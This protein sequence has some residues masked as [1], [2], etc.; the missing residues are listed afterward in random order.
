MSGH[1]KTGLN[2]TTDVVSVSAPA[3][4]H[5]G[6]L[7]MHGGLGRR[8]GGIGMAVSAPATRLGLTRA[9]TTLVEGPEKSRARWHLEAMRAHLGISHHHHHLSITE[10]IPAHAG[11]GSGTQLA[12]AVA[13]ALRRLNNLPLDP[14]GDAAFLG[15]G[16]RSGVGAGFFTDG[17][18]L[19]DGGK[20]ARDLPP[21][22]IA[23]LPF[24][25]AWRVILVLD[26]ASHGLAGSA[27]V[28]AF[29]ALP[30]F[31]ERTAADICRLVLMQ[32]L[33]ALAE[34]DLPN[35]GAALS[36][37][38]HRVGEHF[39][40]AQGG[41]FTSPRV[42]SAMAQLKASGA[43]GIGQSSWGPTGFAFAASAEEA[44]AMVA[45]LRGAGENL[46]IRVVEGRNNGASIAGHV[47]AVA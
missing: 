11:L 42:A 12:L 37:I 34:T 16:S 29:A 8:F 2:V 17:G 1:Q 3:R 19:V 23:R 9:A 30:K 6:F 13:A 40:S 25:A 18:F 10:V 31:S 4:L 27:E 28:D 39:S 22:V 44:R 5:L 24:P 46:D 45:K 43:T 38:Q 15:R 20:G 41:L 47:A 33:P 35:F 36:E 26:P 14:E 32:L 21:P 7:D